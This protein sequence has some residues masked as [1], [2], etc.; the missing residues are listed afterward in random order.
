[1]V[2]Q[3]GYAWD[4]AQIFSLPV[5][6]KGLVGR[7]PGL[8][9]LA[10][11]PGLLSPLLL[12]VREEGRRLTAL[13]WLVALALATHFLAYAV[14]WEYQYTQ[15]LPVTAALA[16]FPFARGRMRWPT[17][18]ALGVLLTLNLPSPYGLVSVGGLSPNGLS[19]MRLWRVVPAL[20][21]AVVALAGTLHA[22]VSARPLPEV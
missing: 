8:E 6:W 3:S 12:A 7:T 20:V 9:G 13:G 19:I 5:L 11:L 22:T 2:A 15:L 17:L 1:M 16:V 10:L 18:V 14:V 4:H 21:L